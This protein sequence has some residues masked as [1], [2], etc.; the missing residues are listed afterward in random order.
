MQLQLILNILGGETQD[1]PKCIKS[2]SINLILK[3]S[4]AVPFGNVSLNFFVY[5]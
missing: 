3:Y 1:L 5:V 4:T 2:A